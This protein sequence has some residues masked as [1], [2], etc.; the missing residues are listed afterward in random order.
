MKIII[1]ADD[2]G[3]NRHVNEHIEKAIQERKISS[4]TIM[5]NMDDFEGA[6]TLYNKY[7]NH[8]S[9]GFHLNLT[10]GHPL[11]YSQLLLDKGFYSEKD[12]LI[13]FNGGEFRRKMLSSR[14]RTEISKEI[15]AQAVRL[16][17]SGIN[18]SHID[19]HH[20]MHQA[21]FM[22]V[23]L[24]DICDKIGIRK[25]RN[26]RNYMPQSAS[27][28]LR[29]TWKQ[30]LLCQNKNLCFTDWFNGYKDWLVDYHKDV[31]FGKTDDTLELMTHPGGIYYDE[32]L[33]MFQTDL[34]RF[35]NIDIIN[36]ND[37]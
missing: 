16:K 21:V 24:P 10:E 25:V 5:A 34:R 33:L 9:F 22:L 4:T 15:M 28:I 30:I 29:N 36:Y 18:I 12:G 13:F 20:F 23:V 37:L 3:Y 32:E 8:I 17:D 31:V 19:S 11:T 14:M 26:Y 2:C 27:R 1:N 7:K 35:D 6:V